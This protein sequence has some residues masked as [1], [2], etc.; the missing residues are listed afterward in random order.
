MLRPQGQPENFLRLAFSR[1]A[2][3]HDG[4]LLHAS[5]LIIDGRGYVFFGHSGAGK[6]TVAG[7]APPGCTLLSDDLVL[8]RLHGPAPGQAWLHGVPFR[9]EALPA[10]RPNASAPL[11]GLYAL[12]QAPSHTLA[13]LSTPTAAAH[14]LACTPFL[15]GDSAGDATAG[16]QALAICT[17]IAQAMPVHTLAFARNPD[18][19]HLLTGKKGPQP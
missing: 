14:L 9:G 11:A 3:A 19:W 13:R 8:L 4:L 1:L 10:P 2:L 15:T 16:R 6:S 18:F 5:G 12:R 7:L 17:R